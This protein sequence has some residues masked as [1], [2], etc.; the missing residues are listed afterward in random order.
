MM[1]HLCACSVR[2]R[3]LLFSFTSLGA[4]QYDETRNAPLLSFNSAVYPPRPDLLLTTD[5]LVAWA[6]T[7]EA[8]EVAGDTEGTEVV[9]LRPDFG[10]HVPR[11]AGTTVGPHFQ[12]A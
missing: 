10:G 9:Y 4:M 8:E 5:M 7:W 2:S 12:A 3:H 11:A 1:Q 6:P